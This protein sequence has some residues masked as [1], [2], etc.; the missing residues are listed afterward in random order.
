MGTQGGTH[1][2]PR[3]VLACHACVLPVL[4]TAAAGGCQQGHGEQRLGCPAGAHGA[5]SCGVSPGRAR[6]PRPCRRVAAGHAAARPP[7]GTGAGSHR[8]GGWHPCPR[9]VVRADPAVHHGSR[10]VAYALL[11]VSRSPEPGTMTPMDRD[12]RTVSLPASERSDRDAPCAE[13]SVPTRDGQPWRL[14]ARTRAV[15]IWRPR[16]HP[17]GHERF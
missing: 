10:V 14:W 15:D 6:T 3:A 9:G 1:V 8:Y 12:L 11:V 5:C 4:P 13:A 17:P 2:R 7:R 16:R